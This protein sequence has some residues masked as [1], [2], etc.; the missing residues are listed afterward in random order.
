M[1]KTAPI[2]LFLK[3]SVGYKKINC[4][5]KFLYLL[6][7]DFSKVF[8][9]SLAMPCDLKIFESSKIFLSLVQSYLLQ[10][11]SCDGHNKMKS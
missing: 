7:I 10:L 8:F 3:F 2:S 6:I 1:P 5:D 4:G 11:S 9:A